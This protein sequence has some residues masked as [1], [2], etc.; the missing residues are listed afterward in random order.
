MFTY[1]SIPERVPIKTVSDMYS[2]DPCLR[3]LLVYWYISV[4]RKT[5]G[6]VKNLQ[7]CAP[8]QLLVSNTQRDQPTLV[9]IADVSRLLSSCTTVTSDMN[10][11]E[12]RSAPPLLHRPCHSLPPNPHQ[13]LP[14]QLRAVPISSHQLLKRF[15]VGFAKD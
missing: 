3:D 7:L 15:S 5:H 11:M 6:N 10:T 4:N 1:H 2:I 13:P 14:P 8:S 12:I 9:V